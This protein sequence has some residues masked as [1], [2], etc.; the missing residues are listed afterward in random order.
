MAAAF[1]LTAQLNLR[2]PN[3]VRNIVADIRRE[4][5]TITGDVNLRI[6]PAAT[7]NITRLNTALTTLNNNLRS[8][9]ANATDA[10]NAMRQFT[11]SIS[12][13]GNTT[14]SLNRNLNNAAAAA[15]RVGQQ[16]QSTSRQVAGAA[17]A[18][19]EFG[20]QSQLAVKRFIAF[21]AGTAGVVTLVSAVRKGI[22]A[23]VEFDKQFV[24][25]QQVTGE[26]ATGLSKLANTI[27]S[28]STGLGVSSS[29]LTEVSSTLAQA[30]L[31]ARDTE[32]ALKAL[33]LSS[34][35][36]S[37]D[38]MNQTVEGSIALMRQ[39]DISA[40]DLE[41]SLGAVNAVAAKFAVESSDIIAAIQRTGGVFASA[42]RGVSEGTDALNEFIAVFTSVRATTRESAETIATGLRTIFTRIQ[43][44]GTIEALKEFGVNL[45]DAEGKFV[46]AYKAVQLLSEGLNR[47]DPRDLKFSEIVEE[48][49]GFRQIGKVI[50]LIQQFATAQEALKVA[51]AG[52]S[53]L[54][55]DAALA[56]L[57]LANQA[58]K[59]REEFLALF[60]EIGGSDTFQTMAK[61]ALSLASALISVAD[62][63]KG[64]LPVLAIMGAFR[65]ASALRQFGSG[66][67]GGFSSS[68]GMRGLGNRLGGGRQTNA[69]GGF[70]KRY[71]SGG[72]VEQVPVALM[73]G[74]AVIFPEDAAKIGMST[75]KRMNY[76]DKRQKRAKG[77]KIGM[78][79]GQGNSDSFYTTL[80]EGSFVIRKAA[81]EAMGPDFI[82]D[83][84]KGRQ[85]FTYGGNVQKFFNA[86]QVRPK[87]RLRRPLTAKE[88]REYI[89][90][91]KLQYGHLADSAPVDIEGQFIGKGLTGIATMMPG[92]S[93]QKSRKGGGGA[94][95]SGKDF[96]KFIKNT[97]AEVLF[98]G[99][100][101]LS[102][103]G[104]KYVLPA[105]ALAILKDPKNL[106]KLKAALRRR[107]KVKKDLNSDE[108]FYDSGRAL[109]EAAQDISPTLASG[110]KT[111]QELERNISST[112]TST[113]RK[114]TTKRD[115]FRTTS[116]LYKAMAGLGRVSTGTVLGDQ[117][118]LIRSLGGPIQKFGNGSNSFLKDMGRAGLLK[119]AARLGVNVPIGIR[120]LLD[121]RAKGSE[122]ARSKLIQELEDRR[123]IEKT[124][125]DQ[126]STQAKKKKIGIVGL[127]GEPGSEEVVTPTIRGRKKT[128]EKSTKGF[129]ATL[130]RG[131]LPPDISKRVR[132][133]IRNHS[134]RI[135]ADIGRIISQSAGSKPVTD[136]KLIRSIMAKQLPDLEGL[137]FESGLASAGAP[138]DPSSKSI[139]FPKGLGKELSKLVGI[140]PGSLVDATRSATQDVSREKLVQ[141]TRFKRDRLQAKKSKKLARGG[142]ANRLAISDHDMTAAVTKGK[143]TPSLSQFKDPKLAVPDILS[144]NPTGLVSLLKQYGATKILTA[145]SGGPRGEM[146]EALQRF[147]QKNG[148]LIPRSQI[149]TLGDQVNDIPTPERKA[150]ALFDIVKKYGS[151]D[152]FDDHPDNIDAAKGVRGVNARRIRI[153]RAFGGSIPVKP[154]YYSLENGSGFSGP[155]FDSL[156]NFAKTNQLSLPEF[157]S[158]LQTRAQQKKNKAG[159]MMNPASLLG[160]ITPET[161]TASAKQTNLARSLMGSPDAKFNPKYDKAR[162]FA[163][164]G[165]VRPTTLGQRVQLGPNQKPTH[166]AASKAYPGQ[167]QLVEDGV[168]VGDNL[169]PIELKRMIANRKSGRYSGR[170]KEL[171]QA[172]VSGTWA[173]ENV[174]TKLMKKA[175]G[176][177]VPILAQEGE[178]VINRNS[179]RAIGYDNLSKLNKYH[180]GGK[181]QKLARGG[182]PGDA[183][184]AAAR[185]SDRL[186][187]I[188]FEDA[189][190]AK[191]KD[192]ERTIKGFGTNIKEVAANIRKEA[193][194]M[195]KPITASAAIKSAREAQTKRQAGIVRT[196]TQSDAG[197]SLLKQTAD[198]GSGQAIKKRLLAAQKTELQ[199]T[200]NRLGSSATQD[201]IDQEIINVK[202][203]YK[204]KYNEAL[205]ALTRSRILSDESNANDS[206]QKKSDRLTKAK[207]TRQ[208]GVFGQ[209]SRGFDAQAQKASFNRDNASSSV[210]K[211]FYSTVSSLNRALSSASAS[212]VPFGTSVKAANLQAQRFVT[213]ITNSSTRM[214]TLKSAITVLGDSIKQ[215]I[216]KFSGSALFGGSSSP[217]GPDGV[218]RDASG[219]RKRG[220]GK[221]GGGGLMSS[222]A[223]MGL[224]FAIPMVADMIAGGEAK[225]E[226][227]ARDNALTQGVATSAGSGLMLGG[228]VNDMFSGVG[229]TLGKLAGPVAGIAV[230]AYGVT[231]A[232]ADA[233]NAAREFAITSATEKLETNIERAS[234]SFDTFQKDLKNIDLQNRAQRD[235]ISATSAADDVQSAKGRTQRGLVNF[236]DTGEGSSE[237]SQILFEKGIG[238]YLASTSLFGGGKQMQSNIFSTMIPKKANQAAKD[239]AG[240][241]QLSSQ[242][243]EQ[244]IRSGDNVTGMMGSADFSKL[245]R[246]L[247]LADSAIQEQI[248]TV[249]NLAGVTHQEKQARIDAILAID[250]EAKARKLETDIIKQM[251]LE[252][253][254]R[255][256]NQLQNSLERMFQ[257]MEQAIGRN[258]FELDKLSQ[259]ADLSAA[260]LSGQA[261]AGSVRLK[262]INVL[263]NPRAYS[264]NERNAEM[265]KAGDMFGSEAG[266]VK[267]LLQASG[268]LENTIMSTINKTI[269]EDPKAGN[270]KIGIRITNSVSKVLEGLKLPPDVS[271]KLGESVNQAIG[272]IRTK[273]DEKIDFGDL[274]EKVPQLGKVMDITRRAQEAATKALE[275]WQGALNDYGNSMNQ[276]VDLQVEANARFRRASDIGSRGQMELDKALGKE[277][278]LRDQMSVALAGVRS[279]TGGATNP[280]DIGQNIRNLE[281]RR[282]SLESMSNTATQR[283]YSGKDEFMLMQDRLRSTNVALRE[284][285]DA[286]KSM[287]DN[288]EM[289]S[290]AM[291]KINEIQQKR[292][293][294]VNIAER[295]VTS[296]PEELSSLNRAMDRLN[297]NMAGNVNMGSTSDQRKESLDAFN[298]IA[299]FLGEQQNSI[300]A[301]VLESMLQESG[302]GVDGMM[303]EVL[304]SLRNPEGDPQMQEAIAAYNKAVEV[305][306][307]ANMELGRLN[308]LMTQNTADI[309]ATKLASAMKEVEF[310]FRSTQLNDINESIKSLISVVKDKP[311]AMAPANKATGGLIYAAAGQLVDFQPKG[312]DTVPAML[313]PGEFVVNRAAT[314]RN[315]PL[316]NKINSGGYSSG[317]KVR[318]YDKGGYVAVDDKW[319][320]IKNG[321]S[322]G[323]QLR[324]IAAQSQY[325]LT[326]STEK[327]SEQ[328]YPIFSNTDSANIDN[329]MKELYGI[330]GSFY[331]VSPRSATLASAKITPAWTTAA[332][333][334]FGGVNLA[335]EP[336][337]GIGYSSIHLGRTGG[338]NGVVTPVFGGA[339]KVSIKS[340]GTF[341]L[342]DTFK[343]IYNPEDNGSMQYI[344]QDEK[345]KYLDIYGYILKKIGG[346][347]KDGDKIESSPGMTT[348]LSLPSSVDGL[349]PSV[350]VT[351]D[352]I[353]I[354][355]LAA[356]DD[357]YYYLLNKMDV[358]GLVDSM[359]DAGNPF[360]FDT[361]YY[362]G[363]E[364]S[365]DARLDIV[366]GLDKFT[367][368]N[369]SISTFS[370]NRYGDAIRD[371][372]KNFQDNRSIKGI[373][374]A[375]SI[376]DFAVTLKDRLVKAMANLKEDS[377]DKETA[378]SIASKN[379]VSN[380]QSLWDGTVFGARFNDGN[381]TTFP[382]AMNNLQS[383]I[384]LYNENVSK[385]WSKYVDKINT[386][387]EKRTDLQYSK[388]DAEFI[389][390]KNLK[391]NSTKSFAWTDGSFTEDD[392]K[393]IF[394]GVAES[395][396]FVDK[397]VITKENIYDKNGLKFSY[398]TYD[399]NSRLYDIV[400][401]RYTDTLANMGVP[402]I[403][404]IPPQGPAGKADDPNR[405]VN[406][407]L[408]ITDNILIPDGNADTIINQLRAEKIKGVSTI[409]LSPVSFVDKG[410]GIGI[411]EH[412]LPGQKDGDKYTVPDTLK[413]FDFSEFFAAVDKAKADR[414]AQA[415]NAEAKKDMSAAEIIKLTDAKRVTVARRVAEYIKNTQDPALVSTAVQKV[416]SG[417]KDI[418]SVKDIADTA[419][420]INSVVPKTSGEQSLDRHKIDAW[421]ALFSEIYQ[422]AGSNAATLQQLGV[423]MSDS[424]FDMKNPAMEDYL[425]DKIAKYYRNYTGLSDNLI[426]S[427]IDREIAI[428]TGSRTST[429]YKTQ[430]GVDDTKQTTFAFG[431]KGM[432]K[433]EETLPDSWNSLR[434]IALDPQ[435]IFP[436]KDIRQAYLEKLSKFYDKGTGPDG[437]TKMIP[438]DRI[439]AAKVQNIA[440]IK[441]YFKEFDNLVNTGL[442]TD[443]LPDPVPAW[444]VGKFLPYGS[445]NRSL[446]AITTDSGPTNWNTFSEQADE[447]LRL[448]SGS[449]DRPP[450]G[451]LKAKSVADLIMASSNL[452]KEEDK[453]KQDQVP[454]ATPA[455]AAG[456]A[457]G[458]MVYA[459]KG[460]LVNYQPRGTDTVP[461]MLTPGEFVINRESTSKYLPVLKAINSGSYS[462]G[463]IVK[464]FNNG[465]I[466]TPR[467]YSIGSNGPIPGGSPSSGFDFSQFMGNLANQIVSAI[468][469]GFEQATIARNN[470]PLQQ[471]SSNGVSSGSGTNSLTT[472]DEFTNRLKS[473]AD[474]LAGLSSIPKEINITAT[475][476]HNVIING[477]AALNKLN[478]DLQNIVWK[479]IS[480]SFDALAQANQTPGAPLT[481]PFKNGNGPAGPT[482]A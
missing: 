191:I 119:E 314:Q 154:N 340:V 166:W 279:Q 290:I 331:A 471:Q 113:G 47:I 228:M 187:I 59:V 188:P 107:A 40:A 48:L 452:R 66:F 425:G 189:F 155:E 467:Y 395:A 224:S 7:Q 257:N 436:N 88:I 258:V 380:F 96:R 256:T 246:S 479:S 234:K 448:E 102:S 399:L 159:L 222:N 85:K 451:T 17:T 3:N 105:D 36:P 213:G 11:A 253:F 101:G 429:E 318:Y 308:T 313:T 359:N 15:Q 28:L 338:D 147:Y 186:N 126:I 199:E 171:Q 393:D 64:V 182:A 325:D 344:R 19:E 20:R 350:N 295:L 163:V 417:R 378:A 381:D 164:G 37:F 151:V 132:A 346:I 240:A 431:S 153:R 409:D 482:Q 415:A 269:K 332:N 445:F 357:Q 478:P 125:Q 39:F 197:L 278:S 210:S 356:Q 423:D 6:D 207:Q 245:T 261:K 392:F 169:D 106:E 386:L 53:S 371:Q 220:F 71:R 292:Q 461:A 311:V 178:Y 430:Q 450:V 79:P 327:K 273:G 373:S 192:M 289:A 385:Q 401:R 333:I 196:V 208:G 46:G 116:A 254:D 342:V 1:N 180:S 317:G 241:S 82:G 111:I 280:V 227:A 167:Y 158:Y 62:S 72:D 86:G 80:P 127:L 315:L 193:E 176:G 443:D 283:G 201:Q 103:R 465:G 352:R 112:Q 433:V 78:V 35:A 74:E 63:V 447:P 305:Q 202:R 294:G 161:P 114:R 291:S 165:A 143:E 50:P 363:K 139:D 284:N 168:I 56:Q 75:L 55:E 54:A 309:A 379:T 150:R 390:I 365:R 474:T 297:N 100:L 475:H 335:A 130:Q 83:V 361:N 286:L 408:G 446:K 281:T 23:F 388:L 442:S 427:I 231:K 404:V 60:R 70:I 38:N 41:K 337:F 349:A 345:Q 468:T 306:Q 24:K 464:R 422:G 364:G 316:L 419:I 42:S 200:L 435:R 34:L 323:P 211:T 334:D 135:V 33:A 330:K 460:T 141:A 243:L 32:R 440:T 156:V 146:G 319:S 266:T 16:A 282:A 267:G 219:R 418:E 270:E 148:L 304:Q 9:Q 407:F 123:I 108:D 110:F 366:S 29:E 469:T 136:R 248:M 140:D 206:N 329:A 405:A 420:A 389:K 347:K 403:G 369:R 275:H 441:E 438:D 358:I 242:F 355:N 439:R 391:D 301:N 362:E 131:V 149:I 61:G 144:G 250:G 68:G 400:A 221:T 121:P 205:V 455:G 310:D 260:A 368:F 285:Y 190:A 343:N 428:K 252:E 181:V 353:S 463:D 293:A 104:S 118:T 426:Q 402:S 354:D 259:Q 237:R 120:S 183:A 92:I 22:D 449:S 472:I 73:P 394:G 459:N 204:F 413:A 214:D 230:A 195:G 351:R 217:S 8:T 462:H 238:D 397:N 179:A 296:S 458:G 209:M 90:T 137:L 476:T 76:A 251:K 43:R 272:Q 370:P 129:P 14:N 372:I 198:T 239:Y 10:A 302:V 128:G 89:K 185:A 233:E 249:Q 473:I 377:F 203:K 454:T 69:K 232:F 307:S 444:E 99:Q 133:I 52:Q 457:T 26:S 348:H 218:S 91:N 21:S 383:P 367:S 98:A 225:S 5:G 298:M 320:G 328:K 312:T 264:S 456:F 434:E 466:V 247:S 229:G 172:P 157:K 170:F 87:D 268:M 255:S 45:T 95:W 322:D 12:G 31:S 177:E 223:A 387:A 271:D 235:I 142:L 25:L 376:V 424:S 384:R 65:G 421:R 265:A 277:I 212:M 122:Q 57:S 94:G 51:Q 375:P 77:G 374:N 152:F 49:G 341:P 477:D 481:N 274:M 27:S 263:Q 109:I 324:D 432:G 194:A 97:P 470:Q 93:N 175:A 299:P 411:E 184:A 480:V 287:A 124:K 336:K 30:G 117:R 145:R 4:L 416:L 276:I 84:A 18:M 138:Y 300:K 2:G 67:A 58:S 382:L 412:T 173:Q 396:Q 244:R 410:M 437:V 160:A 216:N 321:P 215:T 303:A 453:R 339:D 326:N 262:S 226:S 398:K 360:G 162:K 174:G 414:A 236:F 13:I 134:E 406:P 288:T 115:S 44:G 81:T